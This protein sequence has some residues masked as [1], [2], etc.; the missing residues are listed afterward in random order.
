MLDSDLKPGEMISLPVIPWRTEEVVSAV[1]I[2]VLGLGKLLDSRS[3]CINNIF[4]KPHLYVKSAYTP[5]VESARPG[6]IAKL[7]HAFIST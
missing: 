3:I 5:R 1:I 7:K 4:G 2:A 6:N